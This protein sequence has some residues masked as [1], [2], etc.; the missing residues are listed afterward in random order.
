MTRKLVVFVAVLCLNAALCLADG[1]PIVWAAKLLRCP[2]KA[3]VSGSDLA[4]RLCKRACDEGLRLFFLGGAPG[5]GEQARRTLESSHPGIHIVGTLCPVVNA[6]GESPDDDAVTCAIRD[7]KPHILFVALGCPKQELWIAR[8]RDLLG[9]PVCLG[10][11]ASLD[12]IAGVTARAPRWMQR[13]GLEWLWRLAQ[14]P[15]R[16]W[17]RYL[18]DDLPFLWLV[19]VEALRRVRAR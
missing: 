19:G 8:H 10:V 3:K 7:A 15:R 6:D 16:L 17:K 18:I 11:G 9:V 1:M 13:S 14:E 2:L 12:F 4:E 5:I